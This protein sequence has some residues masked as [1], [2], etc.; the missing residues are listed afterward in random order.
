MPASPSDAF[1]RVVN[2]PQFEDFAT[3]RLEGMAG[4]KEDNEKEPVFGSAENLHDWIHGAYG[5]DDVQ[6]TIGDK[7]LFPVGHMFNVPVAAFDP[8]F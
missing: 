8:I 4:D 2:I 5:S 7:N 1:Y 3:K 6:T